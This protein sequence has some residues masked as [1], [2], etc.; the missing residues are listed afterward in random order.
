M[1]G[2]N[3]MILMKAGKAAVKSCVWRL[4][5]SDLFWYQGLSPE[6]QARAGP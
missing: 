3:N 1:A 6:S 2:D 5:V 4:A